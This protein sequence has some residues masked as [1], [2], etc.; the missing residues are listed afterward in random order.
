MKNRFLADEA[1]LVTIEW[2]AIGAVALV[3]AVTISLAVL[4][5][6]NTLGTAVANQMNTTAG[7][8]NSGGSGGSSGG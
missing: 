4:T 2:I 3:A 8:V 6:A 5:G 7:Q 1:G